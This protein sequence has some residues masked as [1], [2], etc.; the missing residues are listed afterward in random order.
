M[1]QKIKVTPSQPEIKTIKCQ[2]KDF[3]MIC[4][5]AFDTMHSAKYKGTLVCHGHII[6]GKTFIKETHT[7][8]GKGDYGKFG[9]T[10]VAFYLNETASKMFDTFE[11]MIKFYNL[12]YEPT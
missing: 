4:H 1:K 8:K 10:T 5:M 6:D 7:K 12:E 9:K 2:V 3:S 11:E